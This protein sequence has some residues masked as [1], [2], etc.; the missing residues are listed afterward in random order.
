MA[1]ILL[2]ES[3]QS[4]ENELS[5]LEALTVTPDT[6]QADLAARVGIAVGTVNWYLKRWAK[7]G[8]VNVQRIGRWQWRYLLTPT[9][10]VRKR[11]LTSEY[12]A[13]SFVLYRRIRHEA[14]HGTYCT[15][16]CNMILTG[17]G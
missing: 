5:L 9:G 16:C 4:I 17:S 3:A 15:K 7:K 13:A 14:R 12:I 2:T 6:T 8:Y 1:Q 10:L 11:Q